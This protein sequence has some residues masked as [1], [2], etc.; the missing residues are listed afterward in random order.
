MTSTIEPLSIEP[1]LP[2]DLEAVL[3]IDRLCYT[4]P[5]FSGVYETELSN[6]AASYFVARQKENV[7]GYAG[8]W[9]IREQAN[10][11]TLAVHPSYQKRKIGERLLITVLEEAHYRG[12]NHMTLE[13]RENNRA[14]Q[15]LYRKYGFQETATRRK[16]YLDNGENAVVMWAEDLRSPQFQHWIAQ[17]KQALEELYRN[18][19]K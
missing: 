18:A 8:L 12:A 19:W 16:Y 15:N 17:Q 1:M 6:R 2:S 5:W 9:V 14:A 11:T 10:L 3:N 4:S 7:A 13:V